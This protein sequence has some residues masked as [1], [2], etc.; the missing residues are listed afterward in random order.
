MKKLLLGTT[1]GIVLLMTASLVAADEGT[2]AVN[3]LVYGDGDIARYEILGVAEGNRGTLYF[4]WAGD[5]LCLAV[6]VD[7][8]VNDNVFGRKK[9]GAADDLIDAGWT[10]GS[11]GAKEH[12]FDQLETS[13][14]LEL[15]LSCGDNLWTWNQGYL[16]QDGDGWGSGHL[17][18]SIGG[19]APPPTITSHSS[20]EWNLENTTWDVVGD[21][22]DRKN[23]RSPVGNPGRPTW[24]SVHEW[25]WALVY[26]MSIDIAIC[27]S[28]I[29]TVSVP[30]AHNSPSKDGEQ[31]VPICFPEACSLSPPTAV[32]ISSFDKTSEPDLPTAG[33]WLVLIL[34][35][36][37][38]AL[39]LIMAKI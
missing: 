24:D 5:T 1:I 9:S 19:G 31:D 21:D 29:I 3:G 13:D 33:L 15:T 6:V 23:W 25:E 14:N 35:S 39:T 28:D 8:G 2:P 22:T 10:T 20:L 30:S 32:V 17:D 7:N 34:A 4:H 27:G 36:V 11:G 26:E 38:L 12:R 37:G 16:Y 18:N